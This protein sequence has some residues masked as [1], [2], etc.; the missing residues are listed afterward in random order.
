MHITCLTFN[1][2]SS[3]VAY[4][5]TD[6]STGI[7]NLKTKK[8]DAIE[9]NHK[10][11]VIGISYNNNDSLLASASVDGSICIT[12][13]GGKG[14]TPEPLMIQGSSLDGRITCLSF[15]VVKSNVLG[16]GYESGKII[17]WDA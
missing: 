11:K 13:Q 10:H 16:A 7:L 3:K 14:A 6:G 8:K 17:I 12:N 15:S 1:N 4:G 9:N 5:C 2:D